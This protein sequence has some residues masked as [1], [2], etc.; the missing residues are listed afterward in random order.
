MADK[1]FADGFRFERPREG[2]PEFVKG[3]L[4]IKVPEAV[5][6]LQLHQ[7]NAGWVN[8]DLKKS[9][10]G[11]LYLE[12]NTFSPKKQDDEEKIAPEDIPF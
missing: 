5:A 10:K 11:T 2:A 3:K 6:F 8:L 7:T 9:K 12:L 4:S 1:I